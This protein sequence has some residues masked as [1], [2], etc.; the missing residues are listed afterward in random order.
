MD[1]NALVPIVIGFVTPFIVTWVTGL[2]VKWLPTFTGLGIVALVVPIVGGVVTGITQFLTTAAPAWY[3]QLGLS[4]VAVF[5]K[6]V[7]KQF[8]TTPMQF[9]FK[10]A[11]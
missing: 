6:E 8:S 9:R 7:M 5:L 11:A 4:L 3:W 2:V 1:F 10:K